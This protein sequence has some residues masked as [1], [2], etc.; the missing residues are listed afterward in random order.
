[1]L[2]SEGDS[3]LRIGKVNFDQLEYVGMDTLLQ[4]LVGHHQSQL[5]PGV[6]FVHPQVV[7][8]LMD[9]TQACIVG[10]NSPLSF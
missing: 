9:P 4:K 1:M 5:V 6:H 3:V 7:Q 10:I 8:H 2:G